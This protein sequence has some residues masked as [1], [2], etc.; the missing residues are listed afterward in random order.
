MKIKNEASY[1]CVKLIGEFEGFSPTIYRCPTGYKTIGYGHVVQEF[2]PVF[3]DIL[4]FSVVPNNTVITEEI[5]L[6]ILK[7]DIERFEAVVNKKCPQLKQQEF[8][9]CISFAFNMGGS[10]FNNST[11]ARLI[12]QGFMDE[13]A[14]QFPR[15]VFGK[16]NSGVPVRLSGLVKRR[17]VERLIFASA[18]K[19]PKINKSIFTRVVTSEIEQLFASYASRLFMEKQI[20]IELEA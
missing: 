14:A 1:A 8:D 13:A 3:K 11:L 12:N 4:G 6:Q 9:A 18:I 15:W 16:D 5:G 2:D 10:A 20:K 17:E 19:S 7:K